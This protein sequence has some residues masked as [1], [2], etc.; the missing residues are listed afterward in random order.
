[1]ANT[2]RQSEHLLRV[3]YEEAAAA[4]PATEPPTFE[5]TSHF[6]RS[7]AWALPSGWRIAFESFAVFL[8]GW[9]LM[10]YFYAGKGGPSGS[11]IGAPGHDS[12]YHVKMA[13]MLPTHGFV[14]QFEWLRF[15][16]FTEQG[17]DFVSHH[18]GFHVLMLPFVQLAKLLT[19]EAIDG[20]RWAICAFFAMSLVL[21][22]GILIAGKVRWRWLWIILF[23]LLPHQFFERHAYVRAISPALM[24]MQLVV[25]LLLTRRPILAG[26]ATL[27][28]TH[29]YLGA[30]MYAPLIVGAYAAAHVFGPRGRREWPWLMVLCCAIGWT[31]GV[32]TYPYSEGM[33]EFL[34]LQVFGSGLTPDIEVGGEWRSYDGV[35]WF[36]GQMSGVLLLTFVAAALL[37]F[38]MGPPLNGNELTLMLLNVGFLMLTLKAR[39]FI[40][41]WPLWALLSAAYLQAPLAD[42]M[43]AW[44]RHSLARAAS[45]W[46]KLLVGGVGFALLFIVV[47]TLSRVGIADLK[48]FARAWQLWLVAAIV[49]MLPMIERRRALFG[50]VTRAFSAALAVGGLGAVV[51]IGG[52]RFAQVQSATRCQYD[53]PAIRAMMDFLKS[54]SDEGDVVFTD[55]WDIF[56]V[57]FYHNSKNHYIVGLDPK[58]TQARR[59]VLWERYVKISRGQTPASVDVVDPNDQQR[60]SIPVKLEDIRDRF[61]A[62]W[63]IV[64]R[65]HGGLAVQLNRSR[66][67]AELVWP[68]TDFEQH[69]NAPYLVFRVRE[70]GEAFSPID[71]RSM[72]LGGL[73]YLSLMTPMRSE[74]QIGRDMTPSGGP[75]HVGERTH[76]RGLAI[77]VGGEATYE[78]PPGYATMT[79]AVGVYDA[80]GFVKYELLL[81]GF[82]VTEGLVA[83]DEAETPLTLDISASQALTLRATG[84]DGGL[85][86]GSARFER[87]IE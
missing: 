52:E 25:L 45:V 21:F 87:E 47:Y 3:T 24:F 8:I 84:I 44:A 4:T 76:L 79:A 55:D 41:Y 58:F 30:V 64:D 83:P 36:A 5:T 54:Q 31:I 1:M 80:S 17:Q 34:R 62:K 69:R 85:L 43:T 39:R 73:L 11:L 81:D 72:D 65:D 59:P 35:W 14:R 33:F 49:V 63:V 60:K 56:P 19:G 57:Y 82:P 48:P 26:L 42:R 77:P 10:S 67:F 23:L 18:V 70:S 50:G 15:C 66:D 86:L 37:R 9:L 2:A 28:Y 32:F 53:L 46:R 22:N 75:L 29:L 27:A 38:R 78:I 20:G 51:L 12:F 68:G 40:E 6:T 74:G 61:G 7:R 16:Y 71:P 13:E